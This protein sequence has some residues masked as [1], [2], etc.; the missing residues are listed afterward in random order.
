LRKGQGAVFAWNC[1]KKIEGR[2]DGVT[3]AWAKQEEYPILMVEMPTMRLTKKER[4]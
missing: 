3:S 2:F 4:E 1:R